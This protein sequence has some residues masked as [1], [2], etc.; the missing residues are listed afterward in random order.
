MDRKKGFSI[1]HLEVLS[2]VYLTTLLLSRYVAGQLVQ[3]VLFLDQ[4]FNAVAWLLNI[5]T[6]AGL[7][8]YF[9]V[10]SRSLE[11]L[12][13]GERRWEWRGED[14]EKNQRETTLI[15][16]WDLVWKPRHF[17]SEGFL[18]PLCTTPLPKNQLA[19]SATEH[20]IHLYNV[21]LLFKA[22]NLHGK[23]AVLFPF[24][25]EEEFGDS[26]TTAQH[27]DSQRHIK[28][29]A[30]EQQGLPTQERVWYSKAQIAERFR[31]LKGQL[32]IVRRGRCLS[33][34]WVVRNN[35]DPPPVKR[36]S[37]SVPA[38]LWAMLVLLLQRKG[39]AGWH[40]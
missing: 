34:W 17:Q 12:Y 10:I 4:L 25:P 31:I 1:P 39:P 15:S 6:T 21:P 24:C 14:K 32:P 18:I 8:S 13:L 19:L 20:L 28:G 11:Y 7:S 3:W 38:Y 22:F 27:A 2:C 9:K 26:S 40:W 33:S 30:V 35:V 5:Q 37:I 23:T 16:L 29:A 36:M